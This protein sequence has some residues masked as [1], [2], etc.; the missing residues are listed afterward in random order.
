VWLELALTAT[1]LLAWTQTMLLDGDLTTAEPK[2]IRYR[3]LH[4]AAR[5][6]RGQRRTRLRL[7]HPWPWARD[8][9]AAFARLARIPAPLTT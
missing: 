3:I 8:L 4:V 6:T 2:K 7:S 9:A 1:D 5:I